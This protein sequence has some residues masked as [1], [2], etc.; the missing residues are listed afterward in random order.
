MPLNSLSPYK[1]ASAP[2]G[3]DIAILGVANLDAKTKKTERNKETHKH[4]ERVRL[5]KT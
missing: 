5:S 1:K 3:G 2:T 4:F